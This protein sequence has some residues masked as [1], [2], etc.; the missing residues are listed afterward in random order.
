VQQ[1]LSFKANGKLLIT[2]EYLVLH[3]ARALAL[4]VTMGQSMQIEVHPDD[5]SQ[6]IWVAKAPGRDWFKTHFSLPTLDIIAT[7]DRIKASKLQLILQTLNLLAPGLFQAGNKYV[8]ETQLDF[9]PEWGFGSSSTLIANLA[10]W[11]KINPYTLLQL[12]IGGS[13]Y[14]I[15]CAFAEN[16]I[17]YQL[18]K[19]KPTIEEVA[20]R[21]SFSNQMF[22]VYLGKK[23]DSAV[24]VQAFKEQS[25]DRNLADAVRQINAI[26]ENLVTTNSFEYSCKL[27]E[28]HEQLIASVIGKVP[29]KAQFPDFNGLVKSLGAW[30]GDFILAMSEMPE[31]EVK[32][33]FAAKGLKTF[34]TFDQ[35]IKTKSFE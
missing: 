24:S 17:V 10:S 8:V 22:F 34:I 3:G 23:Q 31:A 5:N 33:Y 11:A 14:D 35:L 32:A 6:I 18:D 12:S 2:G 21:P 25:G 19:L 15:A 16:P 4:P 1:P 26:T 13:G 20:F 9:E 28:K 29:V 7:D 30:G 27:L